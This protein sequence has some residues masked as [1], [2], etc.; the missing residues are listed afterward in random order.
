MRVYL[1]PVTTQR[2][3]LYCQR[4]NVATTDKKSLLDKAT[5]R[6]AR[7]WTSWEKREGGWQKKV[8]GWGNSAFRRIP[9]EEWGLKSVPPLSARRRADELKGQEKVEVMYPSQLIPTHKVESLLARMGTEREALHRKR[10]IWCCIGMPIAVPFA[11]VPVIPNLPFFYLAYRAWSHW[12]A[13]AGG[14]HL[15]F[16]TQ[17]KLLALSPSAILDQ[18][19]AARQKALPPVS[20][21]AVVPTESA[22]EPSS[23]QGEGEEVLLIDKD[24]PRQIVEALN[25]AEV[26]VELERALW[27]A[28]TALKP[29]K[30]EPDG[31]D[32]KTQ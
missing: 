31:G 19:Y 15:Q 5:A 24:S 21:P 14:K 1:L 26:E 12:R 11:L 16:L 3:L 6:A 32:K 28:E 25:L 30:D 9:F 27:Q 13:I 23:P 7:L 2:T 29:K 20:D 17:K 18:V 8:V 22:E 10:L 4:L